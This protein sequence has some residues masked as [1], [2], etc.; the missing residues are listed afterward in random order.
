MNF[1]GLGCVTSYL[2]VILKYNH[3]TDRQFT[4]IF[5]TQSDYETKNCRGFHRKKSMQL[6][7]VSI[8]NIL[9]P[10]HLSLFVLVASIKSVFSLDTFIS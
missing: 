6:L 1:K 4:I 2:N 8:S 3:V 5:I 9:F 7:Q 10:T